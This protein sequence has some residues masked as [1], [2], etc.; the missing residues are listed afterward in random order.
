MKFKFSSLSFRSKLL[1]S[2]LFIGLAA[3]LIVLFFSVTIGKQIVKKNVYDQLVSIRAN[4]ARELEDYFIDTKDQI[5]FLC[6]DYTIIQAMKD[7]KEAYY[8]ASNEPLPKGSEFEFEKFYTDFYRKLSK[9]LKAETNPDFFIPTGKSAK[10]LQYHYILQN[11]NAIGEKDK[12]VKANDSSNYTRVH[13]QYHDLMHKLIDKLGFYDL[14]LIEPETG[15]ILYTVFKET[16]FGT[17]IYTGPYRQSNLAE[18][19]KSV[20]E[21]HDIGEGRF[22]DYKFYRPSYGEPAAFVAAPVYDGYNFIGILVLQISIDV[23]DDLMTSYKS[24]ENDG[25]GKTGE[26]YIIGSDYLMRS[27]SRFLLEDPQGLIKLLKDINVPEEKIVAIDNMKQSILLQEVRTAAAEEALKG[28]STYKDVRDYRDIEVLSAFQPLNLPGLKWAMLVEKD[29]AEAYEPLYD[30]QKKVLGVSV[31]LIILITIFSLIVSSRLIKPVE[32]LK[33]SVEEVMKGNENVVIATNT[34]DEIGELSED[35][36]IVLQSLKERKAEVSRYHTKYENIV[37]NFLPENISKRFLKGEN[38]IHSISANSTIVSVEILGLAQ[39]ESLPETERLNMFT[40]LLNV[41][42]DMASKFGMDKVIS[43]NG[44]F[45]Y[46]CG[47]ATP[48]LDHTKRSIDFLKEFVSQLQL[49]NSNKSKNLSYVAG[50][51]SGHIYDGLFGNK[52]VSYNVWGSITIIAEELRKHAQQGSIL[53][54]NEVKDSTG[55]YYSFKKSSVTSTVG[56]N[57]DAWKLDLN[58]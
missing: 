4:K 22:I 36:N 24:W 49:F 57:I 21:N 2:L 56:N 28:H 29:A 44:Y 35:F 19:V 12:L 13:M 37:Q 3:V 20:K 7:F 38:N 48:K 25:M 10:Y 55:D 23:I 46:S 16:D 30:F 58:A 47:L 45:V 34:N 50:V 43:L 18:L 53:V 14:F 32:T 15:D 54:S 5:E 51:A 40:E 39:L 26:S 33:N 41:V 52:K 27:N 8:Q 9:N 31:V 6:H 17:N 11:S 1:F 42:E